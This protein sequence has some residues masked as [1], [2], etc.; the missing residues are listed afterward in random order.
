[1]LIQAS[2]ERFRLIRARAGSRAFWVSI[3]MTYIVLLWV[4]LA[5]SGNIPA[6][7][8]NTLT[9]L[10]VATVI[11]PIMVYIAGLIYEQVNY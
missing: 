7:S 9:F 8:D 5:G 1:M 4:S 11:V 6:L 10:L 3:I 2:D